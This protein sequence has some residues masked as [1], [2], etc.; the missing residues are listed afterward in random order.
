MIDHPYDRLADEDDPGPTK[1]LGGMTTPLHEAVAS[2]DADVVRNLVAGGADVDAR[3]ENGRT[4]LLLAA[5]ADDPAMLRLLLDLGANV[6]LQDNW[7]DNPLLYTGVSGS[8]Q[9]ARLANE[10]GADPTITSRYGGIAIISASERGHV[11]LVHYLL[12]ESESNVN[13]VNN[14]GWTALLEAIILGDGGPLH[15]EI[16][17]LLIA[18]GADVNLADG[19]GVMP[20]AHARSRGFDEIVTI[21]RDAGAQ[22]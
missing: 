8:V 15:R 14:L 3:D 21:L 9:I 19:D 1:R 17:R 6:D 10:A 5:H 20:L 18:H 4:P 11:E 2:R 13:H 22:G 7:L 16:V 12:E